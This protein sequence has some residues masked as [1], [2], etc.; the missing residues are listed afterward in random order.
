MLNT[1]LNIKSAEKGLQFGTN[2]CKSMIIGR[3]TENF[4][5][6]S[7]YVDGWEEEYIIN[8]ENHEIE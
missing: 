4:I 2:K 8:N 3:K 5:N 1:I 7:L 6:N